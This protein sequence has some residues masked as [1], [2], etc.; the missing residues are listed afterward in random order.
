MKALCAIKHVHGSIHGHARS[1]KHCVT[2]TEIRHASQL[3]AWRQCH[4]PL[5]SACRMQDMWLAVP[6]LSTFL[7]MLTRTIMICVEP[8]SA[9]LP[10]AV[11]TGLGMKEKGG[12]MSTCAIAQSST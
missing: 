9:V 1:F 12:G 7:L 10:A 8:W 4:R 11:S 2:A 6:V 5:A 3:T